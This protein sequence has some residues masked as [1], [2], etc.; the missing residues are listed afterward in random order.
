MAE[1]DAV[2]AGRPW[3]TISNSPYFIYI[4]TCIERSGIFGMLQRFLSMEVTERQGT[5]TLISSLQYNYG[6]KSL[7]MLT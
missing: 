4:R 2:C 7:K 3:G 6:N 5:V 1:R